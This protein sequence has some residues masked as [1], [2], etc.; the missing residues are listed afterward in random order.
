[1]C[2][3]QIHYHKLCLTEMREGIADLTEKELDVEIIEESAETNK[4]QNKKTKKKKSLTKLQQAQ[5]DIKELKDK[6]LRRLA[7]FENYKKRTLRETQRALIRVEDNAVASFL[8][9]LDDIHRTL[10]SARE[11]KADDSFISGIE[12]IKDNFENILESR[13]VS[14][15]ETVGEE[16]DP[17]FHEAMLVKSDPKQ[18][19]NI[20]L[21]ELE[22]GYK[23][24]DRVL[25]HAKVKVNKI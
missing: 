11:H 17:E 18:K 19:N 16:F 4:A 2:I 1:M 5:K 9:L 10:L 25:R 23:H 12:L 7:E 14:A 21:E 6:D 20:I 15:I 24:N 3:R 8:P 22:K 13:G